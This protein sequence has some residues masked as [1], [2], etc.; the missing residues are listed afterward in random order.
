[1]GRLN[2]GVNF[3]TLMRK[4]PKCPLCGRVTELEYDPVRNMKVF[5]CHFDKVAINVLDPLVGRWEELG[6][7][8]VKCPMPSCER[9]MR[10]FFTSTGAM[11]A[12]CPKCGAIVK[13]T[14]V[15]RLSMPA[16]G[17]VRLDGVSEEGKKALEKESHD[18][19]D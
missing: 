19:R 17:H 3:N 16:A 10:M 6:D 1:M 18:N 13:N 7:N 9:F 12:K 4:P 8:K 5:A 14:N 2:E 15:D 11:V